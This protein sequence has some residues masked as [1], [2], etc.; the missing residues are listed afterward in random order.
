VFNYKDLSEAVIMGSV[1]QV[2]EATHAAIA[3]GADPME[4]IQK[5]L[6]AGMTIVGQRFKACE[7]YIPE[8]LMSAKA[9]AAGVDLVKPL[10]K[11]QKI[12]SKGKFMI[13]TVKGDMHDIGKNLVAL[14]MESSGFEVIN[15]GIDISPER[16]ADAVREHKPHILGL[17]AMLTTTMLAMQDTIEGLKEA[18]LR[19][20]VKVMIGGAPVAEDFAMEIG[21][22]G[23]APD[24]GSAAEVA[25]RL[26][27]K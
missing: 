19:D 20:T 14:M 1:E 10:L 23:Y 3:G 13:G 25:Q 21:A 17:S 15:I 4:I 2:V 11:G 12:T 26:L 6:T 5:G 8:V 27:G 9:M 24:G 18:G 16:F 7:M 22:D